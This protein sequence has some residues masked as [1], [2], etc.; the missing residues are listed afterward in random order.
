MSDTDPYAAALGDWRR[1]GVFWVTALGD[2]KLP[3]P[4][5]GQQV[6]HFEEEG[7]SLSFHTPSAAALHLNAAWRA[8]SVAVDLKRR[9]A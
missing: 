5:A 7:V 9:V 8:A 1:H 6:S 4:L 3:A 2:H